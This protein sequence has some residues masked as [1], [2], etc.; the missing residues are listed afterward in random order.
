MQAYAVSK[1]R[2]NPSL[3]AKHEAFYI[4]SAPLH[5]F[6]LHLYLYPPHGRLREQSNEKRN[7]KE[8]K[9][10]LVMP[11]FRLNANGDGCIPI[12]RTRF[13]VL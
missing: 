7:K 4:F 6:E 12:H 5:I 1:M 11:D 2:R 13:I 10:Q 3:I 9:T 8:W